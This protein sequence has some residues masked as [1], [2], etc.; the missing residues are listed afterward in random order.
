M[1]PLYHDATDTPRTFYNLQNA[2][3]STA[4]VK[5]TVDSTDLHSLTLQRKLQQ[6]IY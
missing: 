2:V 4:N 5:V 1:S 3:R 6:Y